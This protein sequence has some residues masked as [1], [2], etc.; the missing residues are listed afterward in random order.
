[1]TIRSHTFLILRGFYNVFTPCNLFRRYYHKYH[2]LWFLTDHLKDTIVLN[3]PNYQSFYVKVVMNYINNI[4]IQ[5]TFNIQSLYIISSSRELCLSVDE[6]TFPYI[7]TH[8]DDYYNTCTPLYLL[9]DTITIDKI[10][11]NV[12]TWK[13]WWS[14]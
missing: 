3:M 9:K 1:M 5:E 13:V 2:N 12:T 14:I 7:S 10:C 11:D 8:G 6:F 4:I